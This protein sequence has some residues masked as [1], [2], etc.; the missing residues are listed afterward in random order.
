M[1]LMRPNHHVPLFD[2]RLNTA[3]RDVVVLRGPPEEASPVL[4]AGK[5]VLAISEPMTMKRIQLKLVGRVRVSWVE[6]PANKQAAPRPVR[7]ETT[8]FQHE[9]PNLE[10]GPSVPGEVTLVA[11]DSHSPSSGSQSRATN[12]HFGSSI[13]GGSTP[14]SLPSTPKGG[15]STHTL[16]SGNHEFPFEVVLPPNVPESVEGLEGGQM[17]Y[18]LVA[19]IER[20]RWAS[21]LTTRK[22]FRVVRTIGPDA[23]D[24]TQT[25]SITNSWPNKVDYT[26]ESPSKAVAIGSTV[27]LMLSMTPQLKG[28][29]LGQIRIQL[30]STVHLSTPLGNRRQTERVVV[31]RTIPAP[32]GGLEGQDEWVVED[33]MFL[34]PSLSK[35]TQ[36]CMISHYIKVSHKLKFFVSLQNPDGH[37]SELRAS[38]PLYLFISPNIAVSSLD[39]TI[40]RGI[41]PQP[42]VSDGTFIGA[43]SL[44]GSRPLQNSSTS[45]LSL[46]GASPAASSP[47][48]SLSASPLIEDNEDILFASSASASASG[49]PSTT[50]GGMIS[51]P[52][53]YEAHVYDRLWKEVPT[54]NLE[55]PS[56]SGSSTPASRSRRNS[57]DHMGM[58][59]LT[60]LQRSEL[61]AGLRAL[62]IA[63][64]N[65]SLFG[66]SCSVASL[67]TSPQAND[68]SHL[69]YANTPYGSPGGTPD[70]KALSRVPSYSTALKGE[71]DP[72]VAPD[73]SA[74]VAG[75]LPIPQPAVNRSSLSHTHTR[76]SS[77]SLGHSTN[78]PLSRSLSSRSLFE[79]ASRL[80]RL[81][82]DK[83][84]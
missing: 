7:Y 34:P 46:A 13:N 32:E 26:I 66:D 6:A 38:L 83:H 45:L 52:P 30:V 16:S 69:S 61:T 79:E 71:T 48:R 1:V 80:M 58:P 39:P 67:S 29:K 82:S 15:S 81:T 36:D 51:A 21:N 14:G 55:S 77:P 24:I 10:A 56:A 42:T 12:G 59:T 27:P 74:S 2:V 5:V 64:N 33:V 23:F 53:S 62:E 54:P 75:S 43:P 18:S 84:K 25:V 40:P 17:I 3:D 20:G 63:Q 47:T 60:P 76:A 11:S 31:E 72:D 9:W 57:S 50:A 35:L 44:S 78:R 22:H 41:R 73:Y 49:P 37:T 70:I 19:V 28:L 8:I 68:Y 65:G 4:L